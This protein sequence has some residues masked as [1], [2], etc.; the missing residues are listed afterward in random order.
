MIV[1]DS[2]SRNDRANTAGIVLV[3]FCRRNGTYRRRIGTGRR[4]TG[5]DR[6]RVGIW[7]L[8][9]QRVSGTIIG[10]H[11]WCSSSLLPSN[12]GL[13]VCFDEGNVEHAA[14]PLVVTFLRLDLF[15]GDGYFAF[16]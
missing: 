3:E 12:S 14:N 4:G 11:F 13:T 8:G 16:V 2:R 1:V 10:G 7:W 9:R 15:P 5:T 6:R